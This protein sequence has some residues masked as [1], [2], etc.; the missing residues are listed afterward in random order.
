[1]P[2]VRISDFVFIEISTLLAFINHY[3]QAGSSPGHCIGWIVS[4]RRLVQFDISVL[5]YI[6]YANRY[7][8]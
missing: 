8:A 3:N 6:R 7:A 2:V 4:E 5:V 1:V